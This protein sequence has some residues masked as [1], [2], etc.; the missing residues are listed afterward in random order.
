MQEQMKGKKEAGNKN[1]NAPIPQRSSNL[2]LAK[3][4]DGAEKDYD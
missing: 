4:N 1:Q 3:E 2:H